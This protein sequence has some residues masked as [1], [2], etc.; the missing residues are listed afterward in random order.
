M[1]DIICISGGSSKGE[2]DYTAEIIS[3]AGNPGTIIHGVAVKPENLPS[4]DTMESQRRLWQACLDILYLPSLSLNFSS[5]A[6]C[7]SIPDQRRKDHT[8]LA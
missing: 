6:S 7:E 5:A 8:T 1:A 3:M 2:K 4:S